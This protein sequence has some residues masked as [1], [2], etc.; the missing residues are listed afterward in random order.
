MVRKC[1]SV[2]LEPKT[3]V[4]QVAEIDLDAQRLAVGLVLGLREGRSVPVEAQLGQVPADPSQVPHV[5]GSMFRFEGEEL[6][7]VVAEAHGGEARCVGDFQAGQ[8]PASLGHAQAH[9]AGVG[10]HGDQAA[11]RPKRETGRAARQAWA[12]LPR[13][14]V[15]KPDAVGITLG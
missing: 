2:G 12:F 7:T 10:A 13:P 5:D 11:V 15:P 8:L 9:H 6:A 4:L 3:R 1:C 14:D